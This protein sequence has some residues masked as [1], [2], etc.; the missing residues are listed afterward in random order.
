MC[1]EYF[2][3]F[4]L[5]MSIVALAVFIALFFVKAGY[6]KFI[7]KRWGPAINNKLGWVLM[8]SPVFIVMI[9]LWLNSNRIF[10]PTILIIFI[11]FQL[12]YFQRSFIFPFLIKGKSKMPLSIILMGVIFNILNALMQGGWLFYFS[13]E[14]M[15]QVEWLYSPQFIIGSLIF[16]IGMFINI[17]SDRRIRLLRK[18]GDTAHYLPNGGLYNYVTSANYFGEII[19]WTGFAIL[20]WSL[21]GV[22]FAWWTFANLVPRAAMIYKQYKIEF[23]QQMKE[24]KLKRIIPF[25][26]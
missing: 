1:E 19:E 23:A 2:K 11:L 25:I 10:Q 9:L 8:E 16:L 13:P 14:F 24:R 17:D 7:N 12:H 20:T 22:V 26:Y 3:Y 18:P 15:Y 5:A 21:S 4:L 6:G